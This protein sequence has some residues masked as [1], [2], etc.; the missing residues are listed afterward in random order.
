[1]KL[2]ANFSINISVISFICPFFSAIE[3]NS[4]GNINLLFLSIH[5]TKTSA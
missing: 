4:S 3:I 2:K 1:M 5:L